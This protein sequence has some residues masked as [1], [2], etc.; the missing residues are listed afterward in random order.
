MGLTQVSEKGIKDGEIINA[1]INASAAIAGSKVSPNFGSQTITAGVATFGSTTL[2][3]TTIDSL[4]PTL[5]FDDSNS[6]PDYRIINNSGTFEFQD[7]T[8]SYAARI[9][10]NTDGHVDIP[11]NLDAEGGIDVTGDLTVDTNTLYVSSSN[12]RVGINTTSPDYSLHVNSGTSNSNAIFESTD[13]AVELEFKDTTGT[14]FLECRNDFRLKNSSGEKVRIDSTGKVGIGT[15]SPGAELDIFHGTDPE[16][17]LS[18]NTHGDAARILGDADGLTLDGRGSSNEIRFKT[19]GSNRMRINSIGNVG[20]GTT[21][22]GQRLEVRQPAASHAIIAANRANSD[23][24]AIALGNNSSNNGVLSVNNTDLVFGRDTAGT[25]T[26]RMRMLNNGGLTFN[27][28]TAAAN[29]LDDYEEGSFTPVLTFGGGNTNMSLGS[30]AGTYTKIGRH[31]FCHYRFNMTGKGNSTGVLEFGGLPFQIDDIQ[32]TTAVQGGFPV[33]FLSGI[34]T[35]IHEVFAYCWEGGSTLKVYKRVNQNNG[36][37]Q[38]QHSDIVST[39]DGRISF[40][41]MT[42]S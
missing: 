10:I 39:F 5:N 25:F 6:T 20:I 27:G 3:D 11:G 37:T 36:P 22:P 7:K 14:A 17:H 9:K 23:T 30:V 15:I 33:A 4:A 12:N 41:Y 2:G 42:N 32:A 8:N 18:I 16:I 21:N 35:G 38:F 28:D 31:V 1:D 26:E 34:A 24:F 29:A 40:F 19:A 13:T